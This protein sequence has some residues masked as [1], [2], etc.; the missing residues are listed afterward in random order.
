[1]I[2][3]FSNQ[4]NI[5]IFTQGSTQAAGERFHVKTNFPLTDRALII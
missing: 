4:N 5:R 3:H 2:P 1:M